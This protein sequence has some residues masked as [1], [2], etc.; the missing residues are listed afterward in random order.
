MLSDT[1]EAF[2]LSPTAPTRITVGV[3]A[4]AAIELIEAVGMWFITPVG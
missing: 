3:T 2:T 4:Y 1:D